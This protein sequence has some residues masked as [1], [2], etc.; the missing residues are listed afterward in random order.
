M[1]NGYRPLRD[2]GTW[3]SRYGSDGWLMVHFFLGV[4]GGCQTTEVSIPR[5][6]GHP[7]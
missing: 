5:L 1:P 6:A 4:L 7:H 2:P 3:S